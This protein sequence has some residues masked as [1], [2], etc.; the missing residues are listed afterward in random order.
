MASLEELNNQ[1]QTQQEK[2]NQL[3]GA[4]APRCSL[5]L[6]PETFLNIF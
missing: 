2:I 4:C 3:A 6:H 1:L 5:A